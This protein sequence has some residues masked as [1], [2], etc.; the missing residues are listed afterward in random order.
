[1]QNI[2]CIWNLGRKQP[3]WIYT[4]HSSPS[5]TVSF[6][7]LTVTIILFMGNTINEPF[8]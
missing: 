5:P 4:Y 3:F 8:A 1:M 6:A 7:V 2:G